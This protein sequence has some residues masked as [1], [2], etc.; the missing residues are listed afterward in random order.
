L[1]LSNGNI[2][3]SHVYGP[4]NAGT[5]D[6][7]EESIKYG[8]SGISNPAYHSAITSSVGP[9]LYILAISGYGGNY[10]AISQK[11]YNSLSGVGDGLPSGV[12]I[13]FALSEDAQGRLSQQS[14]NF[15]GSE[16]IISYRYY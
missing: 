5:A 3:S 11:A 6:S 8:F 2:G 15:G 13:N 14:V 7:L 4:N 16:A 1:F 10:D 9:L 12:T